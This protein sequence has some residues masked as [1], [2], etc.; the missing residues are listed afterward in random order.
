M[1]VNK[2]ALIRYKILDRCF[3]N[4]GKR[5]FIEDLVSEC[6]KQLMEIDPYS[7]GIQKRQLFEDIKFMESTEG[8][9]AEIEKLPFGKRKYYRYADKNFSISNQPLNSSEIEQL[10]SAME[11]ISRFK[12]MPQFEWINEFTPK[13]EQAFTLDSKTKHIISFDSNEYLKGV[14]FISELFH[15]VLYKKVLQITYLS[16]KN[17]LPKVFI[18]HPYYLKQYNNRWFLFG[19]NEVLNKLTN[20]ALDRINLIE[21]HNLPYH[22]NHTYDFDE[23]FEDI[24]GVTKPDEGIAEK[25]VLKFNE[26]SLPYVLSKPLHGSQKSIRTENEHLI[27]IEVMQNYELESLLLS[28]GERVNVISPQ[29]LQEK[30]KSRLKTAFTQYQL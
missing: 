4:P 11:I 21:E 22:D 27:S 6:N 30:I 12:G 5:Y 23:Y 3:S 20:L 19:H 25:I 2:N 14:G 1:A 28:F 15:A 26:T 7:K 24:I 13:L 18:I 29:H 16:Y 9:S 8:W 10:H 17:D